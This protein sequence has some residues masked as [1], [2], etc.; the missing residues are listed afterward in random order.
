M[1]LSPTFADLSPSFARFVGMVAERGAYGVVIDTRG[2]V[3]IG[4]DPHGECRLPGGRQERK[5]SPRAALTREAREE[6]GW[7]IEIGQPLG[8]SLV[9]VRDGAGVV[10]ARYYRA[11]PLKVINKRPEYMAWWMTPDRAIRNLHRDGDRQAIEWAFSD[12]ARDQLTAPLL[13]PPGS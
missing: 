4:E 2:L 3:L 13:S 10:S 9:V 5:E 8:R 12:A 11:T 6:V 7:S 1:T